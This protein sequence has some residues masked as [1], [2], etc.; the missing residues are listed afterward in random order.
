[1]ASIHL[2]STYEELLVSIKG[3]DHNCDIG[4][5]LSLFD[6][7]TLLNPFFQ[8]SAAQHPW[9]QSSS[10]R[11]YPALMDTVIQETLVDGLGVRR[12]G[13]R[14]LYGIAD[15][16]SGRLGQIG[17][18]RWTGSWTIITKSRNNRNGHLRLRLNPALVNGRNRYAI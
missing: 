1:M 11:H 2:Y 13:V 5:K 16:R 15:T 9:H 3:G 18:S 6:Y 4:D 7:G 12:K 14:G 8:E 10:M 17:A